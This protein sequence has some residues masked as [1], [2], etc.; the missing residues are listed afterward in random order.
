MYSQPFW[1]EVVASV[2]AGSA[3][4]PQKELNASALVEA[5]HYCLSPEAA[6]AARQIAD[7]MRVESGV[8]RAV[9]SFHRNLP[10]QEMVCDAL[11][12]YTATW[13]CRKKGRVFKLSDVAAAILVA[14]KTLKAKDLEP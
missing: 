7:Q 6:S 2:G 1:G 5:L 14:S 10:L 4:I 11:P 8:D 3:P 9:Q 12:E 13:Q